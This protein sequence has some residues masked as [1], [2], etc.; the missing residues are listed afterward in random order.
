MFGKIILLPKCVN[1]DMSNLDNF[2]L[3]EVIDDLININQSLVSP[4][5]KLQYFARLTKN[6][7]LLNFTEREIN[8]YRLVRADVP[9][10]RRRVGRIHGKL[11][12]DYNNMESHIL[13]IE[14][15]DEPFQ[16]VFRYLIVPEGI[17]TIELWAKSY[18]NGN[19]TDDLIFIHP[20]KTRS[21]LQTAFNKRFVNA[22][23]LIS[24][25][26]STSSVFNAEILN[27][28]RTSLLALVMDI[29]E[30]FG[31][32]I[33]I[34]SFKKDLSSNNQYIKTFIQSNFETNISTSG[35]DNLIN[36]GNDS[37]LK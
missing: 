30:K 28:V 18:E 3:Q 2:I 36:T 26:I 19:N 23:T 35:N 32:N 20:L 37:E 14:Y 12:D 29:G 27:S 4:L 5:L 22:G 6:D 10:Y 16:E 9:K 15:I 25:Y 24:S 21:I 11:S 7:E 31:F 8:G 33:L 34:N 17:S 13:P 1:C